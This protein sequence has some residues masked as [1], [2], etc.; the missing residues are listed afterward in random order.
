MGVQYR[1]C[2]RGLR[3]AM[4]SFFLLI[5]AHLGKFVDPKERPYKPDYPWR[6]PDGYKPKDWET[7]SIHQDGVSIY[8][9]CK[10]KIS[11]AIDDWAFTN[12]YTIAGKDGWTVVHAYDF[13]KQTLKGKAGTFWDGL[14][15]HSNLKVLI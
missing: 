14:M 10:R 7:K 4:A 6:I 13:L 11:G 1:G 15:K 12:R 8:L 9:D 3:E 2:V 5:T